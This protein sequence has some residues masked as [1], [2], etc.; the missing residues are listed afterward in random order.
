[1]NNSKVKLKGFGSGGLFPFYVGIGAFLQDNYDLNCFDFET[2]SGSALMCV[3]F[4]HN[5]PIKK[6]YDLW[7]QRISY[8][9]KNKSFFFV[10]KYFFDIIEGHHYEL[11]NLN[12][13]NKIDDINHTIVV[14]NYTTNHKQNITS[15][16]NKKDYVNMIVASCYFRI[17]FL[18]DYLY[19]KERNCYFC[20]GALD[21]YWYITI[22]L[23]PFIY[24]K[25][26]FENL[27]IPDKND[28][29]STINDQT[30]EI[31]KEPTI[32]I[33]IDILNEYPLIIKFIMLIYYSVIG[34]YTQQNW[35]YQEGYQY[36]K[37]HLKP[38]LDKLNISPKPDS[39]VGSNDYYNYDFKLN[40][41]PTT[42]T[43]Y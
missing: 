11:I 39:Q 38:N 14:T 16:F 10:I 12:K 43:F 26:Y 37:T 15:Y 17:P 40:F 29:L 1:M 20:D 36:A 33:S 28:K 24:L 27:F 22:F 19:S 9:I 41:N 30:K 8:L 35:L 31:I 13:T 42:K 23:L 21:K 5:F 3:M 18:Y 7:C 4:I 32:E 25:N 2:T 34:L 6:Y